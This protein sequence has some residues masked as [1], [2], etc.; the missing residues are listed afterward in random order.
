MTENGFLLLL[1]GAR[2][3]K[4]DFAVEAAVRSNRKVTFIATATAGDV[5]MAERIHRHQQQ[6]PSAWALI[7]ETLALA[8]AIGDVSNDNVLIVDCVTMWTS[9]LLFDGWDDDGI[10]AEAARIADLLHARKGPSFIVS[11]EVGLG[12]HPPTEVGRRYRDLLGGVNRILAAEAAQTLFFAAGG[13]VALQD[14]WSLT[15]DVL[16]L[17][18]R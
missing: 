3:G 7:E 11:N 2:S 16:G 10:A 18:D 15:A 8:A 4:S 9:N 13:A 1:G 6:R 14:P 12:V 17:I 5:D